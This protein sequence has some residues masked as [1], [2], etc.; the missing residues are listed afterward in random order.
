[1][2]RRSVP[3]DVTTEDPHG[4]LG[5]NYLQVPMMVW[6]PVKK[7]GGGFD[8]DVFLLVAADARHYVFAATEEVKR[9][10]PGYFGKPTEGKGIIQTALDNGIKEVSVNTLEDKDAY[11]HEAPHK[12][13]RKEDFAAA[14]RALKNGKK[15]AREGWNGKGMYVFLHTPDMS[16]RTT[17]TLGLSV[18]PCIVMKTAQGDLQPG[19]FA[20]QADMLAEDW[21]EVK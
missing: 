3:T 12:L 21:V 16:M 4:L 8:G 10:F 14:I 6:V 19:W 17:D 11:T 18:S 20:S 5:K 1:M 2:T 13:E 15:V 9:N 7:N